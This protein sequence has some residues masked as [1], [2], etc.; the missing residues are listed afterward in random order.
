MNQKKEDLQKE[1]I[2]Y[3]TI[4]EF[5]ITL[6]LLVQKMEDVQQQQE[7]M[8]NRLDELFN[9]NGIIARVTALEAKVTAQE[10]A[11][12]EASK[13]KAS[14]KTGIIVSIASAIFMFVATVA[15][16]ILSRK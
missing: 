8:S 5:H 14:A 11:A 13:E 4:D 6:R 10:L 3:M 7:R 1:E 2:E 9:H 16:N 12:K 15:V